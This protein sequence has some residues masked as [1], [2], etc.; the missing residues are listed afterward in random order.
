MQSII[1]SINMWP[2]GR[3]KPDV[4]H[5]CYSFIMVMPNGKLINVSGEE[6]IG[7]RVV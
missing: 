6:I 3:M 1:E 2:F 7:G 4:Y 5:L